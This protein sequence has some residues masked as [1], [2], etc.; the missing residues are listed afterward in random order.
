VQQFG[1]VAALI[2][3]LVPTPRCPQQ[4]SSSSLR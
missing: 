3:D 4:Q 2:A 1:F